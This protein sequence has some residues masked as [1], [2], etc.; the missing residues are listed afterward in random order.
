[1]EY[2][3]YTFNGIE[4]LLIKADFPVGVYRPTA[5]RKQIN[6]TVDTPVHELYHIIVQ[7]ILSHE[8]QCKVIVYSQDTDYLHSFD[9]GLKINLTMSIAVSCRQDKS[10]HEMDVFFQEELRPLLVGR[11]KTEFIDKFLDSLRNSIIG[12]MEATENIIWKHGINGDNE[13]PSSSSLSMQINTGRK[14]GNLL[15][16]LKEH[17][18]SLSDAKINMISKVIL[19]NELTYAVSSNVFNL[20]KTQPQQ[21]NSLNVKHCNCRR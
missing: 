17:I 3:I 13:L 18:A 11:M 16:T 20:H 21:Q 15:E 6:V 19:N 1:M 4:I 10:E 12:H 5:I 9:G 2:I 14:T 8:P 7:S